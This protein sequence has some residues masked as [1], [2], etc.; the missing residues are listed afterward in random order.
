MMRLLEDPQGPYDAGDAGT[1]FRFMTAY[2]A[3]QPGEKIL[4]GS[5]RM[6]ERPI[7]PLAKALN[8][9]GAK[10][11]FTQ[12]IGYPPLL[13]KDGW[14]T[15]LHRNHVEMQAGVS[16][17]FLSSLAMIGPMLPHGL[18]IVPTGHAVSRPYF[19]MTL[20]VMKHMGAAFAWDNGVLHLAPRGYTP[21]PLVVEA[22]WSSAA[23]WYVQACLMSEVDLFIEGLQADSWQGDAKIAGIGALFGVETTYEDGGIRLT[24]NNRLIT[25][26]VLE[27]DFT[28][29]PD[30]FPA[31]SAL[32][33]GM[34][35]Q[36]L[37]FGMQT[38]HLK[39]SDRVEAMKTEL[40]KVG[41]SL[42]KLP[43]KF[44][45]RRPETVYYL[46]EGKAAWTLPPT[47]HCWNDHRIAM[48]LT[49]LS[50]LGEMCIDQPDVVSKSY[51]AFWSDW[52]SLMSK[53]RR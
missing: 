48:A 24:K 5:D 7:G 4:T 26:P 35:T 47:F 14:E 11:R 42:S 20:A 1:V 36:G 12:K 41:V 46:Q 50:A 25:R 33:A 30:L 16:S 6:L 37:F 31:V 17:Q 8:E 2:L 44:N 22:D 28:D 27:M 10:I 45:K 40:S 15:G 19:D 23:F 43:P 34:G 38:L 52:S 39:E 49:A 13:I 51:P 53:T 18:V 21:N 9:L 29:C 3:I 32:C